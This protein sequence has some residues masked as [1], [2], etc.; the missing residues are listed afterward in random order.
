MNMVL[1]VLSLVRKL[2]LE[3]VIS[4]I[5]S[6]KREKRDNLLINISWGTPIKEFSGW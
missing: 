5:I 3:E 1:F 4:E 6:K 2:T